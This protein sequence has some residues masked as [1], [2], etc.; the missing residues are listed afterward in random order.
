ML[1]G[2]T[3]QRQ[4]VAAQCSR[5]GWRAIGPELLPV[6]G[7]AERSSRC[8]ASAPG[9]PSGSGSAVAVLDGR[10]GATY[11]DLPWEPK[12]AFAAVAESY[13]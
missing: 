8:S 3:Q 5:V 9:A 6:C 2:A 12:A 13:R 10:T 11:P 4:H 1:V 7:E